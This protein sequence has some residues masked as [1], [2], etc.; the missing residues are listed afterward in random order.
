MS[1]RTPA[2]KAED[3]SVVPGSVGN[4]DDHRA[5]ARACVAPGV[6]GDVIDGVDDEKPGRRFRLRENP[7]AG[8][9]Q[10]YAPADKTALTNSDCERCGS[11]ANDAEMRAET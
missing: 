1:T 3:Y 10:Q 5:S 2:P 11:H 8:R 7:A 4:L 9:V 6:G